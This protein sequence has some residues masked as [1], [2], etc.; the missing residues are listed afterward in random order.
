MLIV[1]NG[2]IFPVPEA[3]RPM[4]EFVLVQVKLVPASG[5]PVKLTKLVG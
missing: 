4:V 3:A 2:V 1:V 5:E